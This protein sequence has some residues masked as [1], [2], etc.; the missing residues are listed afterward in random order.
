[1]AGRR[2][3]LAAL[4]LIA[5]GVALPRCFLTPGT[6]SALTGA[7]R[8]KAAPSRSALSARG[9]DDEGEE[10]EEVEPFTG[11]KGDMVEAIFPEDGQ[12]YTGV[13]E[14]K[15]KDGTFDVK[16]DDPGDGDAVVTVA[17]NKIKPYVPPIPLSELKVGQKLT[18]TVVSVAGFGAF[19]NVG[20][21]KDGLVHIS[22]LKEGYVD[23]IEDVVEAG[24]EVTVWV[25]EVN[26]QDNKLGLTM[27]EGKMS[28]GAPRKNAVDLNP[29][30]DLVWGNKI[31]GKVVSIQTF[32]A[33]VEVS[34]PGGGDSA[35][36]LVHISA[37]GEGF[38]SN[39]ADVVSVG[40]EVEVYV[41]DVDLQNKRI[42]LSMKPLS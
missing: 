21:E 35:T 36:G 7:Y 26:L 31:P 33:F 41:K 22:R 29:F 18:G 9:G 1:M 13:I 8:S 23:N 30:M 39:V 11:A 17:A 15:N 4:L 37:M 19:V 6:L 28:G 20:A 34:P 42:S 14:K 38:V 25:S 27:V 16:W 32:G 24:Q 12:W 5:L 2:T 3:P 40:D 10:E